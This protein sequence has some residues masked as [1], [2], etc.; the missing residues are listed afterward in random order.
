ML[1]L[2]LHD[3]DIHFGGPKEEEDLANP[4]STI[5]KE[6]YRGFMFFEDDV[7]SVE[8]VLVFYRIPQGV[9]GVESNRFE[10]HVEN[11]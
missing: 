8:E 3:S 1:E 7:S 2:S 6:F 5:A 4:I 9:V 10:I 11:T